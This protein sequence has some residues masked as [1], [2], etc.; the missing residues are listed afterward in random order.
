MILVS[1]FYWNASFVG[2]AL[3]LTIAT[4]SLLAIFGFI[5]LILTVRFPIAIKFPWNASAGRIANEIIQIAASSKNRR[6]G[7]K[8]WRFGI[9]AI[10]FVAFIRA[11]EFS[12]AF[13]IHFNAFAGVSALKI[14]VWIAIVTAAQLIIAFD[15]I[16]VPVANVN[17]RNALV[18]I[19][20]RII[21]GRA[22]LAP[23]FFTPWTI[24]F[25]RRRIF[26]ISAIILAVANPIRT[27]AKRSGIARQKSVL[28][29]FGPA[30]VADKFVGSVR[31][32]DGMIAKFF[33]R[34]AKSVF[35]SKFIRRTIAIPFVRKI[36]AI[37]PPVANFSLR[38]AGLIFAF[39]IIL[40][41]FSPRT[42]NRIF[43][44]PLET[45][46]NSVASWIK[47]NALPRRTSEFSRFYSANRRRFGI[48]ANRRGFA[49]ANPSIGSRF[50]A[51][52]SSISSRFAD[53]RTTFEAFARRFA[54]RFQN[55]FVHTISI[56]DRASVGANLRLIENNGQ[57]H[58]LTFQISNHYRRIF[59]GKFVDADDRPCDPIRDWRRKD[60]MK[61]AHDL[62][63]ACVH[64]A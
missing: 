37:I 35:A 60:F 9:L 8:F 18:P 58:W 7:D 3:E 41:A 15:A 62:S 54:V 64:L 28:A 17:K 34:N 30:M 4:G 11:I 5:T 26:Q 48:F 40:G 59:A 6:N 16:P 13:F 39:E 12:V 23:N 10:Q 14:Q 32:I 33:H 20:A 51:A 43:I 45:I 61:G 57:R 21:S 2:F 47:I 29:F 27:H 55:A 24:F 31:A 63:M 1:K 52:N 38:D 53:G 50:A 19:Q 56:F 49:A 42:K 44:V 22:S 46:R 25:V 36:A